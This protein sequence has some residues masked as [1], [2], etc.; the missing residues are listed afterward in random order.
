MTGTLNKDV[1][2][3]SN[4]TVVKKGTKITIVSWAKNVDD[5]HCLVRVGKYGRPFDTLQVNI[6][7]N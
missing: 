2:R 1:T 7:R 4:T 3:G 5:G 6:Q